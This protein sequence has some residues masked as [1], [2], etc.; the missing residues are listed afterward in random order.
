MRHVKG[1]ED[2]KE[3]TMAHGYWRSNNYPCL[4]IE[5]VVYKSSVVL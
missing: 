5:D 4:S 1:S 2:Y 3:Y